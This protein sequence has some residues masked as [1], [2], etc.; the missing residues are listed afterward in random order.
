MRQRNIKIAKEKVLENPLYIVNKDTEN[1]QYLIKFLERENLNIELGSGKGQFIYN[2]SKNN[3]N[4]NYIAV[5]IQ[6]SVV[7]R[8]LQKQMENPLPNLYIVNLDVYEFLNNFVKDKQINVFYLNFSD[9]WPKK[10]KKRL[11]Y[12]NFLYLY[13]LKLM[14]EGKI[15]LK[16]DSTLLFESTLEELENIFKIN[17]ISND[18]HNEEYYDNNMTEF[19]EKFK[20]EG[21]KIY[22]LELEKTK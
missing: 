19:E 3:P 18:L 8:I 15:F 6:T 14:D 5:E 4:K 10:P 2:L 16:T 20:Q 13:K 9:P 1:K 22:Y 17:K 12:K 11:T 7:Y 21:K